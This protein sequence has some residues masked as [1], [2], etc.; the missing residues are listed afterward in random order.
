MRA[1]LREERARDLLQATER[2]TLGRGSVAHG[3]YA[4]N[5]RAAR[6][7]E[8]GSVRWVEV[9]YCPTPLAEERAYWEPYFQLERVQDA[10]G[11][12]NCRDA[13][14]EEPWACSSCDCTDKLEDSLARRG[15]PFLEG[16]RAAL[17]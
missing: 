1:R 14:G 13:S 15:E 6:R 11:R 10:H 7:M 8:D 17:P 4:R 5:M 12:S 2:G 9:C 16:L 3:E